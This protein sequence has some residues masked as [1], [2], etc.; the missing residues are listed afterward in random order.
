[1]SE[2]SAFTAAQRNQSICS[3][4]PFCSYLG[5]TTRSSGFIFEET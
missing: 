5:K 3:A 2:G 4:P 1:M